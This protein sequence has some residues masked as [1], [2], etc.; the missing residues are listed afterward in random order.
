METIM[1]KHIYFLLVLVFIAGS[2]KKTEPIA[3]TT[4]TAA[5]A[6]DTLFFIMKQ[7]YY[8]NDKAPVTTISTDAKD[9]YPDPYKLLEAMRYQT[10]DKWSFVADYD[11]FNAEMAGTFVGHGIRIGL[12]ID[13]LARIA[14]IYNNSPLHA[15]GV[16][17]GWIIKKVNGIALAPI[18]KANDATTYNNAMGPATAGY[19][20]TF[21]FQRPDGKD[22]TIT[23]AKSSFTINTVLVYD[24][25]HLKTGAVAGHMVFESFI[26]PSENELKTAF[27]YFKS[28]SV[29]KFILDLR[30]NSGGYLNIAQQ[31][32][33]Y[34]GGNGLTGTTFAKLSYNSRMQ[35]AMSQNPNTLYNFINTA[36]PMTLSDVVV[37]TTR[38]TASASEAVMNGLN[39]H[40]SV[41]S[42]GDTTNGKPVGMNGWSCGNKY[43][44]WPITFKLVNSANVGDYFDG[45]APDKLAIDDIT[46]DFSDKNEVCLKEAIHYLETGAFSAVKGSEKFSR[47]VSFSEKPSWMNNVFIQEK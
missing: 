46:H 5:Q 34:L 29:S 2:C 12:D 10:L 9:N 1:N 30:Y 3:D 43:W 18:M 36:S 17:R 6:R 7:W 16:R 15:S 47:T 8:W 39:P 4:V 42:I 20:N 41:I 31:L 44:F 28:Q 27:A 38:L 23:S 11:E 19:N 35:P 37:I 14:M 26:A 32:A 40:I 22:T 25:L 13:S 45:I 33:S 24:T 21:L